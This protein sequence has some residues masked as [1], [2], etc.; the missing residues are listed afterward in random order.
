MCSPEFCEP[1]EQMIKCG[2]G[3]IGGMNQ[4]NRPREEVCMLSCFGHV[5]LFVTL[6]TVALGPWD[7]RGKNT[8]EGCH[9]LLQGIF[10]TQGL[11]L[12]FL[13]LLHWQVGILLLAPPEKPQRGCGEQIRALGS[14]DLQASWAEVMGD[15]G[16]HSSQLASEAGD[17]PAELSP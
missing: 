14:P 8:G 7:S 16:T 13:R 3:L 12:H 5:R 4:R 17:R 10:P 2:E 15:L 9:A 6:R 1:L 11:N